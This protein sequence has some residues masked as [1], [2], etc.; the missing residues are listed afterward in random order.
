MKISR[1]ELTKFQGLRSAR[2]QL[3]KPVLMATGANGAG[4]SSLLEGIRLAMLGNPERVGLKKELGKLV[5]EGAKR[6]GC[7]VITENQMHFAYTL[8]DGKHTAPAEL[9]SHIGYVLDAQNF[10][11]ATPDVRRATLFALTGCKV[12]TAEITKRLLQ[13]GAP[14]DKIDVVAPMLRSGFPAANKLATENTSQARGSWKAVT[15]E[16]YGEKKAEDWAPSAVEPVSARELQDAAGAVATFE[17]VI[18][19][20]NTRLGAARESQRQAQAN[21]ANIVTLK[22]KASQLQ[23]FQKKLEVDQAELDK[24]EAKLAEAKASNA[25]AKINTPRPCHPDSAILH[26]LATVAEEWLDLAEK[27]QGVVNNFNVCVGWDQHKSLINRTSIH[28]KSYDEIYGEPGP[29]TRGD[30]EQAAADA[31]NVATIEQARDTYR[32]AVEN[33]RRDI[34]AAEHAA[35]QVKEMSSIFETSADQSDIEHFQSAIEEH[36]VKLKASR[37]SLR[38]LEVQDGAYRAAKDAAKKA[39]A[40]HADVIEW[41]KIADALSPSGI[42][43][44]ILAGA[45]RPANDYLHELAQFANWKRVAIGTEMDITADGRPYALLSES[46]KW[47]ADCLLA[48]TVAKL[49]GLKLALLDRFDVLD[50]TGRGDVIDLLDD[51]AQ[52]GEI[53]TAIL[54]GTLKQVPADLP[55]TFETI[56]IESG[57]IDNLKLDGEQAA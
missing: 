49:S 14:Q 35:Q 16:N 52:R 48:L 23:R 32:R 43:A 7:D 47:R 46:E 5:T 22:E 6:G 15:G 34:A 51:L 1:I 19:D 45:L 38:A 28:V 41:S 44:E 31:P 57:E 12:D 27:T 40:H 39:T 54:C 37:E 50:M 3:T 20:L 26:A 9:G 17:N 53:E 55:A 2:L 36:Q 18:A 21:A 13:R 30:A 56:W 4:K 42:P 24:W 29:L 33:D 11:R 25:P 10:A 8:P